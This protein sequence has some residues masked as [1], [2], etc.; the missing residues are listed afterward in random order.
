MIQKKSQTF[1]HRKGEQTM[2]T[3]SSYGPVDMDLHYHAPR[4]ELIEKAYKQITGENPEKGGH[5]IT[6]WAPRQTGKTWIMQQVVK[7]TREQGD[8]EVGILILQSAKTITSDEHILEHFVLNLKE[9]FGKDLPEI[10]T[11]D[12]L[13]TVFTKEYF[14]KPLILDEFDA[15]REDFR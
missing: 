1:P 15:L 3:F 14:S 5:Y 7:K 8:F 6:V 11:W 13:H 10:R 12:T 9:W 2:R 4:T